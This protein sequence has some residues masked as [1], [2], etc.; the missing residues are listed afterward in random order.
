[1]APH[2]RPANA[3]ATDAHGM[4]RRMRDFFAAN[5]EGEAAGDGGTVT[6]FP[7]PSFGGVLVGHEDGLVAHP[8]TP[9]RHMLVHPSTEQ[10]INTVA[11]PHLL[12]DKLAPLARQATGQATG[13]SPEQTRIRASPTPAPGAPLGANML[14]GLRNPPGWVGSADDSPEVWS[15]PAS[16]DQ[17]GPPV[18]ASPGHG[19]SISRPQQRIRSSVFGPISPGVSYTRGAW[20]CHA[21]AC[22]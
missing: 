1:L 21:S 9:A 15:S 14:G 8:P 20:P 6:P 17:M 13:S 19:L 16:G 10:L 18:Q 11:H 4:P 7:Q 12:A 22:P 2:Q 5:N 3:P